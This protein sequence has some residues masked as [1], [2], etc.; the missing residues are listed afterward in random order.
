MRTKLKTILCLMLA[1]VCVASFSIT[2]FASE[3]GEVTTAPDV[4]T[5]TDTT[6]ETETPVTDEPVEDIEIPFNYTIDN[7]GNLII[8][9]DGVADPAEITTI[10]TVVTNGGRLNLRTGAGL[11]FEIIDQ[12]RPGEEVTVIGSEGDWYEVIVPEKKG[13]VHSDYLELIEKAEQNSELDLAMLIHLMG[14]M[15]DG[16]EGFDNIFAGIFEG[17]FGAETD[18]TEDG[19]PPF[20]FTPDGN[21]TLIDD[22]LQIEV[23]GD[24]ETEQVEKQFITVQSKNGNTFYIVIDRNGETENVYFL[25]LVDE[26]DLMAL[27]ESEEGETAVPTCS[28]TDK[29]VVGAINTN[30]EICRTNMSECTGKEPVVE[31]EPEQPTEPVEEPDEKKSANFL[32]LI[33]VLIAGAGGFAVYWFKFRK[34][35]TKTTGNSD[36]DDYDFGQDDEDYDEETELDDADVMAEA[37]GEDDDA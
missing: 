9:I 1:M 36:L 5:T 24:E 31:P 15:F 19:K 28:C 14:M 32:P 33:I 3:G 35:K 37:E 16:T 6:T 23:P 22:F 20:A 26:A 25:N 12:L 4:E 8:T 30:C 7:D 17:F 21:M 29:C 34:P 2:A 13:Y 11:D 18:T 27:M 10:G